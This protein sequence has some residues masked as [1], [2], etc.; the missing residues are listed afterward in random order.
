MDLRV[1]LETTTIQ[2]DEAGVRGRS[3]IRN[4]ARSK[5]P[6]FPSPSPLAAPGDGRTPVVGSRCT[7]DLPEYFLSVFIM[8]SRG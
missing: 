5:T 8:F 1:H 3:S 6:Q 7:Y 2:R 4:E